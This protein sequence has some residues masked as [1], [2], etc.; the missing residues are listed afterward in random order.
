[1]PRKSF[2][3]SIFIDFKSFSES[4][5]L[6]FD[7][8]ECG[9]GAV[10]AEWFA[11]ETQNSQKFIITQ[12]VVDF[13]LRADNLQQWPLTLLLNSF[14]LHAAPPLLLLPPASHFVVRN[15][16][17]RI[18]EYNGTISEVIGAE[19]AIPG[20]VEVSEAIFFYSLIM[21]ENKRRV[22]NILHSFFHPRTDPGW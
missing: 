22:K 14:P 7:G 8:H 21:A 18:K 10:V 11:T 3:C 12:F 5:R 17:R 16:E 4:L 15:V 6:V 9:T 20:T 1:M 19:A 13:C 2:M